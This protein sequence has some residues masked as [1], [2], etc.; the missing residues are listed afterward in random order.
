VR[1]HQILV[2][3]ALATKSVPVASASYRLAVRV[4]R[5]GSLSAARCTTGILAGCTGLMPRA[6]HSSMRLD[7][8]G[9]IRPGSRT[10]RVRRSRASSPP[11]VHT[12][13]SMA[14]RSRPTLPN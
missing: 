7:F 11:A 1:R 10:A 3:A 9:S 8:L 12:A 14:P 5:V 13:L 2:P 4:G 6:R